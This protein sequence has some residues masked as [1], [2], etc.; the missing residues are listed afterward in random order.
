M[1]HV[2]SRSGVATLRTAIHLLLTY[3]LT[4][5]NPFMA[6]FPGQP[7]LSR[8]WKSTSSLDLNEARDDEVL[9]SSGISWTIC[10][11][12]AP[13]SRQI[14]TPTLH[15]SIFIGRMLF[16]KRK[17]Q[18]QSTKDNIPYAAINS[19]CSLRHRTCNIPHFRCTRIIPLY[20]PDG[21]DVHLRQHAI[22]SEY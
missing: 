3:L 1:W 13:R 10:Q 14:T 15:H 6:S 2:S 20:S 18:C 19:N 7:A 16:L 5:L 21:A 22:I 12:S 9:G 11:Q 17:Q 8:Y 4:T